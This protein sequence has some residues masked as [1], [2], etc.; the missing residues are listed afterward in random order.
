MSRL[1]KIKSYKNFIREAISGTY[2]ISPLGPGMPRQELKLPN[3][4]LRDR[5]IWIERLDKFFTHDD[6]DEIY[7]NY[8][9]MGGKPLFG[10]NR[11][12]LEKVLDFTQ[13]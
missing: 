11:E 9:K 3:G 2:D 5:V 10:F 6:W 12:N 7:N 13:D 1:N 4:T 8:L